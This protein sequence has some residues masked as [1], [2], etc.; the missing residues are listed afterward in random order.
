MTMSETELDLEEGEIG[1]E[2]PQGDNGTGLESVSSPVLADQ[3]GSGNG[4]QKE[5][6]ANGVEALDFS[7]MGKK[8]R[9]KARAKL[10]LEQRLSLTP[11]LVSAKE[12]LPSAYFVCCNGW[13]SV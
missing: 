2:E 13:G 3:N 9:K 10:V 11:Q 7:K 1:D 5:F 4:I 8:A 6:V 12:K